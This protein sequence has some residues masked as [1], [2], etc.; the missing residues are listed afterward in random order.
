MRTVAG[1]VNEV[2]NSHVCGG[3]SVRQFLGFCY[4]GLYLSAA[5]TVFTPPDVGFEVAE[6]R[7]VGI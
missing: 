6:E 5:L 1:R 2:L 4:L 3:W 7:K